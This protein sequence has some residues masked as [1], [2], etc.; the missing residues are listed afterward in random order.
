MGK[1]DEIHGLFKLSDGIIVKEQGIQ[2]GKLKSYIGE[3][4]YKLSIVKSEKK[5]KL[6]ATADYYKDKITDLEDRIKLNNTEIENL[7]SKTQKLKKHHIEETLS[8]N[9]KIEALRKEL[10]RLLK[11]K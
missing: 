3:L 2:I 5:N 9:R 4:E 7:K 8:S 10:L 1:D 11:E 6:N